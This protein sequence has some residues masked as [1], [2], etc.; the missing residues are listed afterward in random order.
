MTCHT[1]TT[2]QRY[3]P[4]IWGEHTVLRYSGIE[5]QTDWRS[6]FQ[7]FTER[8]PLQF[9]ALLEP[10][11]RLAWISESAD[12]EIEYLLSEQA[13]FTLDGCPVLVTLADACTLLV[14]CPP[15][16]EPHVTLGETTYGPAGSCSADGT[17]VQTGAG[18]VSIRRVE[19][20]GRV[21]WAIGFDR[22]AEELAARR[23][24]IGLTYDAAALTERRCR[25]Y[26]N[27]PR[28]TASLP[29]RHEKCRQKALSILRGSI[30]SPQGR[31]VTPWST[32]SARHVHL[33]AWDTLFHCFGT[34]LFAPTFATQDALQLLMC[35]HADGI[36]PNPVW[37]DAAFD[38][39]HIHPPLIGWALWHAYQCTGDKAALAVA[40]PRLERQIEWIRQNRDQNGNGLLEWD[41]SNPDVCSGGESGRD[42]DQ[43]FD[44]RAL[45]DSV[46]LNGFIAS[47][48]YFLR[49]IAD[50]LGMSNKAEKLH[51]EHEALQQKYIAALWDDADSFL[52]DR[53][54]DGTWKRLRTSASF[55]ALFGRL[56][57]E[58]KAEA[59]VKQHL[60]NPARFW[61]ALPVPSVAIDEPSFEQNMW[62]GPVWL[63]Y[64]FL[65]FHGL[66]NYGYEAAARELAERTVESV[67]GWYEQTGTLYEY[68][69]PF[70]QLSPA[71]LGRKAEGNGHNPLKPGGA[72]PE[73]SWSAAVY[74][75]LLWW[76]H[77]S[78]AVAR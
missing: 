22:D 54:E 67:A 71:A 73:F 43:R 23:A 1:L 77:G 69:D 42:N 33:N 5:G 50:D 15:E 32:P 55:V 30:Q 34:M 68:Y 76:L 46:D 75:N 52:Y 17:P 78:E 24:E 31:L 10:A 74:L 28:P 4:D 2:D 58:T 64:S 41:V 26:A 12:H 29:Q 66:L 56:L 57:D 25:W 40:L 60:L 48:L 47:E 16:Q 19:F 51:A 61:T 13:R 38:R 27:L 3:L 8:Q 6:R 70:D 35:Q 20:D 65:V 7:F 39:R 14:A 45:M 44:D 53:M 11:L 63:P 72:V 49:R 37:P 62:R 59:L 9:V 21:R 36:V 18:F